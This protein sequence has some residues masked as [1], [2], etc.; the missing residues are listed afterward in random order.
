MP[1]TNDMLTGK[2]YQLS[3]YAP[4]KTGNYQ[5]QLGIAAGWLPPSINMGRLKVKVH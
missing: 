2:K 1:V 5:L 3:L 4:G